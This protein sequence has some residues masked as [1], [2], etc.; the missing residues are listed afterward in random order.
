MTGTD[1]VFATPVSLPVEDTGEGVLCGE[2]HRCRRSDQPG[3]GHQL[4]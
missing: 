3:G 1:G 4:Q 2:Y